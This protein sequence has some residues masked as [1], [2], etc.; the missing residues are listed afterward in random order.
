[1]PVTGLPPF[2]D[3]FYIAYATN[4][5]G[6]NT[7][8]NQETFQ[9]LAGLPAVGTRLP[10]NITA[11]SADLGGDVTSLGGEASVDVGVVWKLTDSWDTGLPPTA[12]ANGNNEIMGQLVAPG[13]FEGAVDLTGQAGNTIYFRAYATNTAGTSYSAVQNFIPAG[14]PSVTVTAADIPSITDQSA[15]LGGEVTNDNGAAVTDR[16]IVWN[17]DNNW[18]TS[19]PPALEGTV[20]AMNSGPNPF[21]DTVTGLPTDTTIYYKAYAINSSGTSYSLA[22]ESFDTDQPPEPTVQASGVEVRRFSGRSMRISWTRGNG[23]GSIVV[24]RLE[25]A[26]IQHPADGIDYS[27]DSNYLGSPDSTGSG[28][29][30]VHKGAG[31]EVW[32]TGLTVN[33]WYSIAVY[34]YAGTNY[35]LGPD[36]L[37]WQTSTFPT[38]NEDQGIDCSDCHRHGT[39]GQRGEEQKNICTTCHNA[40]SPTEARDNLMFA[41]HLVPD[42]NPS[43]ATVD[44]GACHELHLSSN[45]KFESF[46]PDAE[47]TANNKSFVRADVSKYVSTAATNAFLHTDQPK[48]EAGNL[49]SSPVA[50]ALTPDRAVEGGDSSTSRGLCQACHT[51]TD[52]HTHNPDTSGSD[53][54]HTGV[55][56]SPNC[57]PAQTH[58][59]DC[60]EHNN[61]FRGVSDLIPC[62]DCHFEAKGSRPIILD[63]FGTLASPRASSHIKD[64]AD[65]NDPPNESWEPDCRVCHDQDTHT[66]GTVRLW[67]TDTLDQATPVS[68]GQTTAN[69]DTLNTGQGEAFAPNCLSCH[70]DQLASGLPAA[71]DQ[72]PSSPFIRSAAPPPIDENVWGSASHNRPVA[73]S[74]SSPVTCVGNGVN[75][76]HGSGHGS[77]QDSLLA[78][79]SGTKLSM[80]DFC[81]NC[82][83]GDPA[84]NNIWAEFNTGTNYRV[85][86]GSGAFV[87]Q[88]HDIT[89]VVEGFATGDQDYSGAAVTCAD[90]HRPHVDNS[91]NK[92]R[93]PDTGAVLGVYDYDGGSFPAAY[94]P[95]SDPLNPIGLPGTRTEPDYIE[96]CLVCHDNNPPAGVTMNTTDPLV[97]LSDKYFNND[98]HGAGAALGSGNG[99]LKFPWNAAGVEDDSGGSYAALN[100]TTCHGVHG[101]GN[102]HNLRTSINVAGEQMEVG[103]WIGDTIGEDPA[104]PGVARVNQTVYTMPTAY[105]GGVQADH[106]WG[107]WC[108]FCHNIQSH[109]K[110][111]SV[112]CTSG[113]I[114]GGKQF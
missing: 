20:W 66:T 8:G 86:S 57:G 49:N 88:R 107:A 98:Q 21:S 89:N 16:G 32:V 42:P 36:E 3:I 50:P 22:I 109:G 43:G 83:D 102:Q 47:V 53:Q 64:P 52:Y 10:N 103:G 92:V 99:F 74:G 1:V 33:T 2:D 14:V 91:T 72:T 76:C 63:Q 105:D 114:H 15:L 40:G 113:H 71:G 80:V 35:L 81:F 65:T 87:N 29:F 27:P 70:E 100:C 5:A 60:H 101:S 110:D 39:F 97:D 55:P 17:T 111:E 34:E 26:V 28:N 78:P 13:T 56:A 4:T 69:A 11:T 46:N 67:D 79:A 104:T 41:N 77:N 54:C 106:R 48:R 7:S 82:H 85:T 94:G 59:G 9:T 44:C 45:N 58:C 68:Y 24:L 61:E 38:H 25:P 75:G 30:V 18:N 23:E 108:S 51:A 95:G 37:D 6:T 62:E 84:A 93:N 73:T 96:F 12:P 31:D 112:S 90:C 19:N